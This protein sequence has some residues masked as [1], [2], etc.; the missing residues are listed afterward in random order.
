VRAGVALLVPLVAV[1][2]TVVPAAAHARAGPADAVFARINQALQPLAPVAE[3]VGDAMA[4]L[5]AALVQAALT[6]GSQ[7][8]SLA[9]VI[10]QAA[11]ALATFRASAE[12]A[13]AAGSPALEQ[14]TGIGNTAGGEI[15]VATNTLD[16]AIRARADVLERL[17]S[18]FGPGLSAICEANAQAPLLVG[19][20]P[21]G[22]A[23]GGVFAPLDSTCA[24]VGPPPAPPTEQ[25]APLLSQYAAIMEG[26]GFALQPLAGVLQPAFEP[27]CTF[28]VLVQTASIFVTLPI[29][30]GPFVDPA[31]SAACA[32]G[33]G[34]SP[35]SPALVFV[36]VASQPF[37]PFVEDA[38]GSVEVLVPA[39][40]PLR[41][42]LDPAVAGLCDTLPAAGQLGP[43]MPFPVPV[44]PTVLLEATG[45]LLCAATDLLPIDDGSPH[46][47]GGGPAPAPVTPLDPGTPVVEQPP[48]L[49]GG[50]VPPASP[51]SVP[52][53]AP[54]PFTRVATSIGG[55]SPRLWAPLIPVALLIAWLIGW[56][57]WN[58]ALGRVRAAR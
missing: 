3:Q 8:E 50:I 48:V 46:P 33:Q 20:L 34:T 16:A 28:F 18:S 19:L 51:A 37:V 12:S 38:A 32:V 45:V 23:F 35:A 42:V 44:E 29:E 58:A 52:V 25:L 10:A 55:L 54:P 9:P 15:A 11:E 57:R 36:T 47:S 49:D 1:A 14:L 22:Y 24:D 27:A 7:S 39:I 43:L 53:A 21:Y 4:R 17:Y 56:M 13:I 41:P 26:T 40:D 30:T 5:Q 31:L 2:L 6:A